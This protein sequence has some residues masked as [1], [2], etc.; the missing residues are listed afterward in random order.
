MTIKRVLVA[1]DGSANSL[2]A[3]RW[4]AELAAAV[5]AEVLA[6][7]ALGLLERTSD[8]RL[9]PSQP[10]RREVVDELEHGWTVPLQ[11]AGIRHRCLLRDGP[12]AAVV[13]SVAAEADVD[14]IVVGSRGVGRHP[15]RLLGSTST[16]VA[17]AAACPVTIVPLADDG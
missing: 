16:Q 12:P 3:V 5:D 13:L 6:V 1:V 2:R 7:H 9:T 8:D 15:E 4:A 14:L 17:Q 10:H 11:A